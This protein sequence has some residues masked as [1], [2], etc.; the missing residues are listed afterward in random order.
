MSWL[1]F[2]LQRYR[3][4]FD[5]LSL[6]E[7]VFLNNRICFWLT[8]SS[9]F[10]CISVSGLRG[11]GHFIIRLGHGLCF[12]LG[13]LGSW[14]AP[15]SGKDYVR[16]YIFETFGNYSI[17]YFGIVLTAWIHQPTALCRI[18]SIIIRFLV[19]AGILL[20]SLISERFLYS[21]QVVVKQ[22]PYRAGTRSFLLRR[23]SSAVSDVLSTLWFCAACVMDGGTSDGSVYTVID[24]LLHLLYQ[25]Y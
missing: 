18:S 16:V 11:L 12:C 21:G 15:V 6:H 7:K 17:L 9:I 24:W 19:C 13:P 25:M 20:L 14:V 8:F 5:F 2:P 4:A 10:I 22:R 1:A 3:T 23:L